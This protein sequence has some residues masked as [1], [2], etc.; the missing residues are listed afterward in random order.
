MLPSYHGIHVAPLQADHERINWMVPTHRSDRIRVRRHT[1]DCKAT[2][3]ELCH[4]GGVLFIRRTI[5]R[6]EGN[7][8]HETERLITVRMEDLWTRLILGQAR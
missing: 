8:V 6:D 7:R 3:Y 1:C 2:I 4:A 5:R